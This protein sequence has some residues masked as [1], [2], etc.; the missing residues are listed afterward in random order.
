[1][2]ELGK[3]VEIHGTYVTRIRKTKSTHRNG[4]DA[5]TTRIIGIPA[6][7]DVTKRFRPTVP[8]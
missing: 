2:M 1:M 4:N 7:P 5:R 8:V 3:T 6:T